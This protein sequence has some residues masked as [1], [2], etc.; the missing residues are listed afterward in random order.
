MS[1]VVKRSWRSNIGGTGLSRKD[2]QPCDYGAFVPDSL[3]GRQILLDG[4]VAADVADAEA[5]IVRLNAEAA[6]LVDTEALARLLLRA[7]AV[8]SSR[9]E[10]LEIGA[11]QLLHA[12]V[13]RGLHEKS[14]D[15]TATEVLNNIDAVSYTHLWIVSNWA[16]AIAAWA[17]AGRSSV[18]QKAHRSSIRSS[19]SSAGGGTNDA[20]HGL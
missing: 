16:C 7:E 14:A 8:A 20:E 19:T 11:R 17:T 12:E 15:G 1:K 6:T 9:L 5:A 13:V 18:P 4:E 10:G 2:S 3:A